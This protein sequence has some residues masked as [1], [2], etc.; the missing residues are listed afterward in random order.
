MKKRYND[1]VHTASSQK[2]KSYWREKTREGERV[3]MDKI[4]GQRISHK[5]FMLREL[6]EKKELDN[7]KHTEQR[8]VENLVSLDAVRK[9]FQ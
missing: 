4:E 6:E 2:I 1:H 9:V 7:E 5:I 8:E 3:S